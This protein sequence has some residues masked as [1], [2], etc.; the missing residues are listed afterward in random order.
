MPPLILSDQVDTDIESVSSHT[1]SDAVFEAFSQLPKRPR[2]QRP[3]DSDSEDPDSE[4]ESESDV[5]TEAE[6]EVVR[7]RRARPAK[8]LRRSLSHITVSDPAYPRSAFEGWSPPLE[9][10]DQATAISDLEAAF[11]DIWSTS[12]SAPDYTFFTLDDFTIYNS[13]KSR[14]AGE[15]VTLDKLQNRDGY[16]EFLF[17]GILSVGSI[18]HFLQGVRFQVMAVNGYGEPEVIGLQHGICIQ[19]PRARVNNVWFQ[20]GRP[21]KVYERFYKPFLWLAQFTKYFADFLLE[22]NQVTLHDFRSKFAGWLR[23]R[24]EGSPELE[25]WLEQCNYLAD[26]RTTIAAHVGYLWKECFSIDDRETGLCKHPLWDE[27]N[28]HAL[29]AIPEQEN[30][31]QKTIV[32]PFVYE[33]FKRRYFYEHLEVRQVVD[34]TILDTITTR[35]KT[36]GLTPFGASQALEA[37]IPTPQSLSHG[38]D[39]LIDVRIGDVICVPPDTDS[40]WRLTLTCSTWFAYVQNIRLWK[41]R[42]LLDLIWLYEPHDTTFGK[43]YYPFKNELF[44][45][46]NCSCGR[47]AKELSDV[48]S[49]ADVTWFAEDPSQH[50]GFFV[51]QTFRTILENDT[52]D[53]VSLQKSH[54][55]CG[56]SRK[57]DGFEECRKKYLIGDTVLVRNWDQRF[58]EDILEPSQIIDFDLDRR[59]VNLR[60]L[61]RK[62]LSDNDAI[63]NELVLSDETYIKP[64]AAIIRKCHVKSFTVAQV[65][66]GLPTPYDRRGAGDFFYIIN[67]WPRNSSSRFPPL[68]LDSS[69][70]TRSDLPRLKSMGIFCGGGNFDRGLEEGGAVEF[71]YAIDWATRAIHSY[72]ANVEEPKQVN[73]FLGSVNDYLAQAISGSG[74]RIVAR[75]GDVD[76]ISA[77]SPCPGFSML[78]LDR[79]SD[80]SLRNASMVSSVVSYVDLYS[81]KYLVLENV[82]SMTYGMGARQDE[83]VFAQ[84]LASLVA[85][86]YQ[87][88]QF[89]MDAWNYSSS[90]SRSRVFII[91][92]APGLEPLVHPHHT[93]AHPDDVS[94]KSLGMSSNSM[95]FGIRRFDYT[96][97]RHVSPLAATAD[98][99]NIG[100]SQPQLCPS[101]PDHRT[102]SEEGATSRARMASVPL[103]PH[104]IGLVQAVLAGKLT[105]E[106]LEWYERQGRIRKQP[107]SRSYS[108]VCRNGLFRTVTTALNIQCG[109]SGSTL[110]WSQPRSLTIMELR[111]AQGFRDEDVIVGTP[112]QQVVI[113]G[114]SVDR[115]VSLALGLSLKESWANSNQRGPNS[116]DPSHGFQIINRTFAQRAGEDISLGQGDSG[117]GGI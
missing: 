21:S 69:T 50:S 41:H 76:L 85:L 84:V 101:F 8:V 37:N 109:I 116:P 65:Q 86:G 3:K 7:E 79:Q 77:G 100:D 24:F 38:S 36:L 39:G 71:R 27:V 102:P 19:S 70:S 26:F 104:G 52:Y 78:Q 111:R 75:V 97:F 93:H 66:H 88:Q 72:R 117:L 35:K 48:I 32:T 60:K 6:P 105:G 44:M 114:N 16:N 28:P 115:N 43:A 112:G 4:S 99:P 82:V 74:T 51:R 22:M 92:S 12:D 10:S 89:L 30:R 29:N 64:P 9:P 11:Y 53:F 107:N 113:I 91:A 46:D 106:P 98:L 73:F 14:H 62:T 23:K 15:M 49:K 40:V 96:P 81:P 90:Q 31:E 108:R 33:M 63:P 1:F 17:D 95:P 68:E 83:N 20:L 56:C 58:K 110:H 5:A 18:R 57:P 59:R 80:Q 94:K 87:T 25:H 34:G 2:P 54:F 55:S 42:T 61:H 47:E 45:S 13:H 103:W 67:E